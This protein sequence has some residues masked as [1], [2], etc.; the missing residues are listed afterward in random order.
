MTII[1]K[2][3]VSLEDKVPIMPHEAGAEYIQTNKQDAMILI[4]LND[5]N[6]N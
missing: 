2:K 3:Y 1:L 6:E 5:T 4:L